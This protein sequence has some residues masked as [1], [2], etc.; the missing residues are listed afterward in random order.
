MHSIN[1]SDQN[2]QEIKAA[3]QASPELAK[4]VHD[5]QDAIRA[6][7]IAR[8]NQRVA[9]GYVSECYQALQQARFDMDT[10]CEN[11]GLVA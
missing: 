3:L 4:A 5:Y 7:N 11:A 9:N 1:L 2:S 8:H 10:L 6:L